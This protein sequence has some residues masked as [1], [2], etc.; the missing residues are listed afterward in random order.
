M[1][2]RIAALLVA[3]LGSACAGPSEVM[4]E[5]TPPQGLGAAGQGWSEAQRR[6]FYHASQGTMLLP[7]SWFLALER[8]SAP[9]QEAPLFATTENLS[10]YGFL[11]DEASSENPLGLPVGFALDDRGG[12]SRAGLGGREQVVGLTCAACHTG[13]IERGGRALRIDGGPAMTNVGAFQ[14]DLGL[15][16]AQTLRPIRFGRFAGRVLKEGDTPA[17]RLALRRQ[18][19]SMVLGGLTEQAEAHWAKV[20]PLEEGYGRLDALGR[21]GNFV[22]GTQARDRNN[23]VPADGPVSYPALWDAP[24]FDWVQYNGAIRQPMG[25]NVAEAMGVRAVTTVTGSPDTLYD[26]TVRLDTIAAMEQQLAGPAPGQGLRPPRWPEELLGPI[27]RAMAE[28]GAAHYARL[29]AGC[30]EGGAVAWTEPDAF[31][32]R[33]RRITMVALEKIGTDPTAAMNFVNR[34]GRLERDQAPIPADQ[35]LKA[36]TDRVIARWYERNAVPPARQEE[37]NGFQP[38]DWRAL[39]AYRAKPLDGAWATAPFLHNG[40]VPSL[41]QMLL[42][43]AQRDAVFHVG[44]R[45]FDPVQVGFVSTP[46][47]GAT[48]FDTALQGNRN[49]GHE[50]RNAPPGT[51]GV[52]GPELSEPERREIVEYLKTR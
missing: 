11:P 33:Y 34:R 49:T 19:R 31:G 5:A 21:G 15:A 51:P 43:A 38:N 24:W 20:Y 8:P 4:P 2:K 10:R 18:V 7:V 46:S 37:M 3:V 30:H 32:R 36:V 45:E 26:S 35:A 44:R 16:L 40:S 47:A 12:F 23:L 52:L 25:R 22:F 29:C 42:P 17:A 41:Y 13:Q 9:F 28:R 1:R 48:R 27:D 14:K 39:A 50:F 6:W